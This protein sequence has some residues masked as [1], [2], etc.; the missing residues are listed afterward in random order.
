MCVPKERGRTSEI[1]WTTEVKI[2]MGWRHEFTLSNW[3][4]TDWDVFTPSDTLFMLPGIFFIC[5]TS[6]CATSRPLTRFLASSVG[7]TWGR[8]RPVNLN[9]ISLLLLTWKGSGIES[10]SSEACCAE[11]E[12]VLVIVF[13]AILSRSSCHRWSQIRSVLNTRWYACWLTFWTSEGGAIV[14]I[15][16]AEMGTHST[17]VAPRLAAML[18]LTTLVLYHHRD[19]NTMQDNIHLDSAWAQCLLRMCRG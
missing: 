8:M 10:C 1:V 18:V 5:D 15:S 2:L 19:Q 9:P 16:S 13:V 4:T 12:A 17:G 11:D 7:G 3:S 14:D 6:F